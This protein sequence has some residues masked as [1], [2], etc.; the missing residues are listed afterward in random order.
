MKDRTELTAMLARLEA[1][2]PD[3]VAMH[4]DASDFWPA[5]AGVADII[6]DSAGPADLRWVSD[7]IMALI[8]AHQVPSPT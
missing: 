7:A 1:A 5:F 2:L 4:P 8:A 3:M 6:E